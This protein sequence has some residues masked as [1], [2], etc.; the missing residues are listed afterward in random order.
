MSLQQ[1]T[2]LFYSDLMSKTSLKA[3]KVIQLSKQVYHNKKMFKQ[4]M[5]VENRIVEMRHF[6]VKTKS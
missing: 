5:Y 3:T 2:L 1:S 4:N 6:R